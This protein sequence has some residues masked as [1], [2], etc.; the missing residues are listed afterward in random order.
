SSSPAT[1]DRTASCAATA[2]SQ[3]VRRLAKALAREAGL[4]PVEIVRER[5]GARLGPPRLYA[6]AAAAPLAGW[7]LSLSHDGRFG[8]AAL[9][10][11]R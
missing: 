2:E 5:R 8:A 3:A 4:G 9:A 1:A 10:G 7:D 6:R 11:D